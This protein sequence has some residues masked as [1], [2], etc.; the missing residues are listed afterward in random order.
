[1]KKRNGERRIFRRFLAADFVVKKAILHVFYNFRITRDRKEK[2][3]RLL[4]HFLN[5]IV[6]R[7]ATIVFFLS[8][9]CVDFDDA[10]ANGV[11][12]FLIV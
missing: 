8:R 7:Y 6:V 10:I 12:Q 1:M 3:F 11:H 9:R 4:R 5:V 2:A